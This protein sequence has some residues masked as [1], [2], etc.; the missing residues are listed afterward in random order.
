MIYSHKTGKRYL[1]YKLRN[2]LSL[3]GFTLIET[4]LYAILISGIIGGSLV[5]VYGL[6]EGSDK[7]NDRVVIEEEAN[8][9]LKKIEWGL[10][11]VDAIIEPVIQP[12]APN[13]TSSTLTIL[14]IGSLD[15]ITFDLD[16][17]NIRLKRGANAPVSLNTERATIASLSFEHI[18]PIGARPR[19]IKTSLNINGKPYTMLLYMRK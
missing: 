3:T 19:A 4:L 5:S 14:K 18:A 12:P 15:N 11:S 16:S 7:L 17:G 6:L 2:F 10:S 8:F 13:A 1:D 9:L